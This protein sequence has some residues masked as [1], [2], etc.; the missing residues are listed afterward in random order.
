MQ[1]FK[2]SYL[3]FHFS[4]RS[5]DARKS[6]VAFNRRKS[7]TELIRQ[8]S[9]QKSIISMKVDEDMP[10]Q[11]NTLIEEEKAEQGMV[12]HMI[13]SHDWSHD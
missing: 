8:L 6:P 9:K 5:S 3:N 11:K 1:Q 10:E 13:R 12:G 7:Q 4:S 2:E